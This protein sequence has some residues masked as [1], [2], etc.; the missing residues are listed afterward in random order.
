LTSKSARSA[1]RKKIQNCHVVLNSVE[2]DLVSHPLE[3]LQKTH[4][5]KVINKKLT[6]KWSF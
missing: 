3:E 2:F 5:K 6:E 1:N 4:A